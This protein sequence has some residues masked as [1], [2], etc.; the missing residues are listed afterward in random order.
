MAMQGIVNGTSNFILSRMAADGVPFERALAEAQRAGYAEPDPSKDISGEDAVEKL[1]V[2]LRHFAGVSVKPHAIETIGIDRIELDDLRQAAAFGA[3]VRPV[4]MAEWDGSKVTAYAG[5]ALVA[6]EHR[7]A[8]L[9]GVQN[10]LCLRSRWSGDLCFSGPGAGPGVTAATVLD[11][12]VE[13]HAGAAPVRLGTRTSESAAP[14]TGWFVRLSSHGLADDQHA[15]S[16]L[17]T[18][19]IRMRRTSRLIAGDGRQRQWLQ[20]SHC[21]RSHLEAALAVLASR[22]PCDAWAIRSVE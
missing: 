22:T 1:C 17:S 20:T 8:R 14:D 7:L 11:D 9:D 19:G 18:L 5:P 10:G 3:V 13:A 6:A 4:V 16:I 12:V 2:L 15:P 21:G